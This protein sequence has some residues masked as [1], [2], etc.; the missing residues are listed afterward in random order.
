[1]R[2]N[3][4]HI[5]EESRVDVTD[6]A[7]ELKRQYRRLLP[8]LDA[9]RTWTASTWRCPHDEGGSTVHWR[10]GLFAEAGR[11]RYPKT[12]EDRHAVG[13]KLKDKGQPLGQAFGHSF[14]DPPSWCYPMMWGYGGQEVDANG[15]VAI[16]SPAT[17]AAVADM[18]Q[19]F[20][21]AYD[22]TGL[23]W[24]DGRTT[25]RSWPRRS[26]R[27]STAPASGSSRGRRTGRSSTTS[28]WTR[29]RPARRGGSCSPGLTN[30]VIPKYSKNVDAAKEFI[31]WPMRRRRLDAEVPAERQL[32]RR[33]QR[34]A[35]RGGCRGTHFPPTA[36]VFKE[37]GPYAR[38]IGYPG[39]P[40]QKAGLAWSK[41]I[42]VDMF[43]RAI[44][45]ESPEAAVEVGRERAEAG[46]RS[47]SHAPGGRLGTQSLNRID[48]MDD[49]IPVDPVRVEG[50][51]LEHGQA[52]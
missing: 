52:Q 9:Y 43:A 37:F 15:K 27:R 20:T 11:H 1:M 38:T 13:K 36:Q 22:D 17:I 29:S 6:V 2:E 35:R 42:I 5:Y 26:R 41:Y 3:W 18:K 25:A 23:A 12:Y 51:S 16:N 40:N 47:L 39:P 28:G 31:R 46:L 21:D 30:Y 10:K 50:E 14:G 8:G 33:R 44:Q 24:D 45:G 49:P 4:A 32:R 34:E 7:E 19:A 48:R